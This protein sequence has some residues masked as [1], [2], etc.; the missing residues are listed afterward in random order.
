[1]A[2]AL[3]K[4]RSLSGRMS[5][6]VFAKTSREQPEEEW[7][8]RIMKAKRSGLNFGIHKAFRRQQRIG[9]ERVRKN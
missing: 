4:L 7:P 3:Q 1:L 9:Y 5:G 2:F 8:S 6:E